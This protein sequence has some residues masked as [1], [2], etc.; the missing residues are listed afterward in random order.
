MQ[1]Y[2]EKVMLEE[3]LAYTIECRWT[4]EDLSEYDEEDSPF[5]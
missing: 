4:P 2:E 3:A 1:G 5:S